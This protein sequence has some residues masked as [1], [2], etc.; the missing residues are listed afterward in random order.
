MVLDRKY[1][2]GIQTFERLTGKQ[3]AVIINEYDAPL[4][5]VMHEDG[6]LPE[7]HRVQQKNTNGMKILFNS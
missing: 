1:P 2:V 3:V 7:F 4:L 6:L 5:D